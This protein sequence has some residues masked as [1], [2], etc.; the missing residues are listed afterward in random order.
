M[1]GLAEVSVSVS[2]VERSD[3]SFQLIEAVPDRF[4]GAPVVPHRRWSESF[5]SEMVA[6]SLEPGIN[7]SALAREIGIRP[8]QLF[9]WR[10]AA[11]AV[12]QSSSAQVTETSGGAG[13]LEI[14][15]GH[16]TIR[17]GVDVGEDQLRR[18]LRAV[19]SA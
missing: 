18:V 8:Q 4:E 12:P 10:R 3:K 9:G 11:R 2:R 16:V 7:V 5:K 15:I 13:T 14:V 17:F 19:Q 1:Q 6:R